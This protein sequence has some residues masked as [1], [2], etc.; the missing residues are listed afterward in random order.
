MERVG[1]RPKRSFGLNELDVKLANHIRF[2]RGFFVEVGGNDGISQSNTA[3]LERY[4]GWR[5]LLIEPIPEL[6][7]ARD[8]F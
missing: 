6:A 2:R 3:Y 1:A 8:R 7:R 5:G 4:L